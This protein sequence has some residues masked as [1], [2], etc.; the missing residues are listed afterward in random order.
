MNLLDP[1]GEVR[2]LLLGNEAIVRG[3]LEA[4]VGFI[5]CYPGTPSS[6][7]PDTFF[8][9]SARGSYYFEYAPNEK[10]AMETAGAAALGGVPTLVTMKHVGVN[11]AADPMMTLAYIGTPGG[12]VIL[13]AD[14][15]GCHSS[16]NEQDNRYY[17]RL[18]G[19][20]CFEPSSA[21]ECKDMAKEAMEL[22]AKWQQPVLLRTTT[23]INHLRG[24]V[25]FGP[26]KPAKTRGEFKKDPGRFVP[27]PAVARI[28]HKVLTSNLENIR[29]EIENCSWN[30]SWGE[31]KVGVIA[32]G[33]SRSYLKDVLK[34]NPAIKVKVLELGIA[35]PLPENTIKNF[36][37]GLDKVVILEELE[38]ILENDVRVLC[39]K[40]GLTLEVTGKGEELPLWDEY[41]T[42]CVEQALAKATGIEI[43]TQEL[44]NP[45]LAA[46]PSRPPNLCAGCS[47]RSVYV[48]TRKIFGD[49]AI[50]SSDIGCYTLG[51]LPPL[52]SA[53]FLLCM[54]SSVSSGCGM[55]R[56]VDNPVIAF[57]GD[58]TFFHSG[59]T[60]LI[61]AVYNDYDLIVVILDNRT[62]AMT[63]HQPHPGV[64]QALYGLRPGN[65]EIEPLVKASGVQHVKKV[66]A[67][68]QKAVSTALEEF[69][70][71]K[72]VRVLIAE[73][74]CPLYAKKVLGIKRT[75]VAT[76]KTS[77]PASLECLNTLAC[78]AFFKDGETVGVNQDACAGC[79]VC[80][81]ICDEIK[82]GSRS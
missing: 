43:K 3:A 32:S 52:R 40:N 79:M 31:G 45:D 76:I 55:S 49:D 70:E 19:L 58:S 47:H 66:K 78:P 82:P 46:L 72:G 42:L 69:K 22:S 50:Y 27:I 62:T 28:R 60:G 1:K 65:I 4:G 20:P 61:N 5:S 15:P 10:V 41:S 24:P 12:L 6:E 71:M 2:E 39:Q 33:V 21:Q 7:V 73:D 53:D 13:S 14:D 48:N 11:V 54:G 80:V 23:R 36:L 44:C 37:K 56:V 17:A 57:I 35:W 8:R 51:I 29:S 38:P 74:P 30:K 16:Q 59:V 34:S 26:M 67:L 9:L 81:Q 64:D 68:N 18:A 75:K 63:G 77:G 25:D